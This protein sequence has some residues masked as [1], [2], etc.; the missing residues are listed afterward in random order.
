MDINK[1]LLL[2]FWSCIFS[3]EPIQHTSNSAA[4]NEFLED[5]AKGYLLKGKA[6]TA[7][8]NY[9]DFISWDFQPN[10][11][12]GQYTYMPDLSF[13]AGVPGHAYSSD[14]SWEEGQNGL[15]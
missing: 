5:R 9:G 6:K 14:W 1:I 3:A 7:I 12:W 2:T 13:V 11:L 15:W 4:R 8:S 10:G